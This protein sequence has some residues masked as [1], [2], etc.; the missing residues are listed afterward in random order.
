MSSSLILPPPSDLPSPT[1]PTDNVSAENV[2]PFVL[3]ARSRPTGWSSVIKR[4]ILFAEIVSHESESC[5]SQTQEMLVLDVGLR[6]HQLIQMFSR[7]V[8]SKC[9][10]PLVPNFITSLTILLNQIYWP[11]SIATKVVT[12]HFQD[13]VQVIFNYYEKEMHRPI[14]MFSI[15]I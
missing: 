3:S 6:K 13:N 15:N 12:S 11:S 8:C 10:E 4:K 2:S 9:Y 1:S 14:F 7:T 5:Y